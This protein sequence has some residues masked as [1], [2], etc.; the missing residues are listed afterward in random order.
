[1][2]LH[3][4]EIDALDI[5]TKNSPLSVPKYQRGY[6]WDEENFTDLWEDITE[7][8]LESDE[9]HFFGPLILSSQA[10]GGYEIV[11][12]QQRI[13][14]FTIL[15]RAMYDLCSD[16]NGIRNQMYKKII[17]SN[18][19]DYKLTLGNV[20]EDFFEEYIKRKEPIRN[21]KGKITSHKKIRKAYEFFRSQLTS[22]ADNYP[23]LDDLINDIYD[24]LETKAVF[25][26]LSVETDV[27]A[28]IIF[29]SINAKRVDLTPAE[30]IK[31]YVFSVAASESAATLR[32]VENAWKEMND[33]F[34][35]FE[36]S[37]EIT[38]YIRHF[39]TSS[40]SD[41]SQKQLYKQMKEDLK[42]NHKKVRKF[43]QD[44][45]NESY[46]YA[47]ILNPENS[48][49][50]NGLKLTSLKEI[51]ELGV[52]QA[53]PILL[54]LL[55]QEVSQPVFDKLSISITNLFVRRSIKGSNPNEVEK[56]FGQIARNIRNNLESGLKSLDATISTLMPTD[57]EVISGVTKAAS[58][59]NTRFLLDRYELSLMAPG[60][61]K[62]DKPT[63]EHIMPQSPEKNSDWGVD[64][65]THARWVNNLGN[66]TLLEKPINSSVKNS[67]YIKKRQEYITKHSDMNM[68]KKLADEYESWNVSTIQKRA[69]EIANYIVKEWPAKLN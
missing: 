17:S 31:N 66:L 45:A 12:G 35:E 64:E 4:D 8:I 26:L 50:S 13:T 46:N 29:E 10:N 15:I 37:P 38:E 14:T 44:I 11:D 54:A 55:A 19:K 52:K 61:K 65:E 34:A 33:N 43:V 2:K 30:L 24:R 59:S 21:R 53:Q 51:K 40:R 7:R 22:Y 47:A 48:E 23:S 5:F 9:S 6:S 69:S 1:M 57:E 56:E 67:A 62:I 68:T 39:W 32:S 41:I 20:D 27:D 18:G 28:Y 16:S 58:I 42:R 63:L 60:G 25:L 36:L 3:H 49:S